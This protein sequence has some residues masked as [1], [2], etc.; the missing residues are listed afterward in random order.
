MSASPSTKVD[1][2]SLTC[3]CRC[4]AARPSRSRRRRPQW[5]VASR[6]FGAC[7]L[8]CEA[9]TVKCSRLRPAF[10]AASLMIL[11]SP[12]TMNSMARRTFFEMRCGRIGSVGAAA[13]S[14]TAIARLAGFLISIAETSPFGTAIG[15][16]MVGARIAT[17]ASAGQAGIRRRRYPLP[18]APAK[19]NASQRATQTQETA[20][21]VM[22]AA[23]GLPHDDDGV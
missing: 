5:R 11:Q 21:C 1:A 18:I 10:S 3:R 4:R 6:P 14:R 13:V 17:L 16:D 22:R 15:G 8:R 9:L 20:F 19:R 7:R 23:Q 12:M 2:R